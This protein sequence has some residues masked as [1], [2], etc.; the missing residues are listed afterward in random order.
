MLR[1]RVPYRDPGTD[2][3]ALLVGQNAPRWLRQ[4]DRFGILQPMGD[5]NLR[6][7]WNARDAAMQRNRPPH[8]AVPGSETPTVFRQ[9]STTGEPACRRDPRCTATPTTEPAP[10][11]RHDGSAGGRPDQRSIFTANHPPQPETIR[12]TTLAFVAILQQRVILLRQVVIAE[13]YCQRVWHPGLR[14]TESPL[15]DDQGC[16]GIEW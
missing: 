12:A 3:E 11:L 9:G 10:D 1:D 15:R 16:A 13:Q 7:N 2:Y 14:E 6:V 8:C 5:G 4:L